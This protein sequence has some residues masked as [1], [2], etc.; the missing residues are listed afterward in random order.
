MELQGHKLRYFRDDYPGKSLPL[1]TVW[2]NSNT[3]SFRSL[4]LQIRITSLSGHRFH[5]R[6]QRCRKGGPRATTGWIAIVF[7]S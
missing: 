1:G 7:H 6:I 4:R 5:C 2:A 3:R